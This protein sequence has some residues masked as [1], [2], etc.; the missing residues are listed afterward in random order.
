[1]KR[2]RLSGGALLFAA[3]L[4]TA[5]VGAQ[6]RWRALE[7]MAGGHAWQVHLALITPPWLLFLATLPGVRAEAALRFRPRRA[8]GTAFVL[9]AGGLWLASVRQIGGP[10]VLNGDA[11]GAVPV[12]AVASGPYRRLR[13]PIYDS[14]ALALAG[15]ALVTGGAGYLALSLES[16]IVLNLV[17]AAV[18]ERIVRCPRP[19][20]A[21]TDGSDLVRS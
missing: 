19:V 10:R 12:Q 16:L 4:N 13:H 21:V 20:I 6:L 18:E 11:F 17:E 9:A 1:M 14:Y 15:A 5:S 2:L 8:L 3:G 7:R